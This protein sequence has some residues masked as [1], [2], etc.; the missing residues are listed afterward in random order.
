MLELRSRVLCVLQLQLGAV[1]LIGDTP[2]GVRR[3]VEVVGGRFDGDVLRG[4]VL[5]GG[6]W[7]LMGND[8]ALRL[9][10]R[11]TLQTDDGALIYLQHRGVRHGPPKVMEALMRGDAVAAQDYYFRTAMQF[12]TGDTRYAFL[13][14]RLV[15]GVGERLPAGPSYTVHEI[16]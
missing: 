4:S 6:D 5:G 7:S 2:Q 16:L 12:E 8:G 10:S 14:R 13:Q 15:I 1:R 3:M 11:T 9:D